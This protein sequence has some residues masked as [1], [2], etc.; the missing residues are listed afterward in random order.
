MPAP[1]QQAPL[2][3]ASQ[4]YCERD[5]RV[6][7]ARLDFTLHSGELVQVE[8]PNGA[9]KTT[10]M[11]S[12]TGLNQYFEGEVRW[13]GYSLAQDTTAFH[14]ETLALGHHSGIKLPLTPTENLRWIAAARGI[15]LHDLDARIA[16]S[17]DA[18][19]LSGFEH[20]PA[21]TLSAGQKRRITLARLFLE[22]ATLWV[23]DEPFSAID[24]AGVAALEGLLGDHIQRGGAALVVTHHDLRLARPHHRLL[25]GQGRRGEWQWQEAVAA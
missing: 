17:L 18:V 14:A 24:K 4:L 13:R 2:L 23:L 10:L 20:Q 22:P 9:G 11:R 12:L 21:H 19:G 6:L 3:Q 8:G 7:F 1:L 15:S 5:E 16:F 25:L